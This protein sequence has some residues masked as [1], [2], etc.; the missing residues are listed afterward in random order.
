MSEKR[1]D[2]KGRILKTGESQRKD[3]IYMYRHTDMHGKRRYVYAPTLDELR[4]HE[5]AIQ[6]DIADG[7]DYST[8]EITVSELLTR[9]MGTKRGLSIN[10]LNS[11]KFIIN[12]ISKS[13]M[14]QR[15]IKAVKPSDV[16]TWFAQL[17]DSGLKRGTIGAYQIIL[18][19]AFEMAVE[20]DVLRKNSFR[21][22]LSDLLPQ[23]A[24]KRKALTK[25]QQEKYLGFVF[26]DNDIYYDD[27]VILLGTGIRVSE[28][29]GLTKSDI[30]FKDRRIR[31]EKQLCRTAGKP[32]YVTTPKSESGIRE[33]PMSQMVYEALQRV[34]TNRV[35]PEIEMII[36]GYGDFLF[37]NGWGNPKTT[38]NLERYMMRIQKEYVAKYGNTIPK[39]TPHV[40]RH[41][42][43][44][45]I[46]KAGIDIKSLQYLMGHASVSLSLDTYSHV[47]FSTVENAFHRVSVSL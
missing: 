15:Q 46:Q 44:S 3:G 29:Y 38:V 16:K 12:Q 32:Y 43:C 10:T 47:D 1:K 9:Y 17:H 31:I 19:P 45:N 41:T 28:L 4:E 13:E 18:R 35:R 11:Y 2:N 5:K 8:G 24:T 27:I 42:F 37:L 39:V 6:R 7:V 40:L 22:R 33:I 30:D 34:V 36:D 23:D 25:E 14:G 26:E 20:D 21:V